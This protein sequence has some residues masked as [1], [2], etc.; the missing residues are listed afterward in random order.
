[1]AAV[2]IE[3]VQHEIHTE[4]SSSS[5][6]P[7][8]SPG[9]QLNPSQFTVHAPADCSLVARP[10]TDAT[11]NKRKRG[12]PAKDSSPTSTSAKGN[13]IDI[14]LSKSYTV[15]NKSAQGQKNLQKNLQCINPKRVRMK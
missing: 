10:S 4:D 14:H 1:M 15:N 9:F 2:L 12:R 5:S 6:Q 7:S 3:E 13:K 8:A 11:N